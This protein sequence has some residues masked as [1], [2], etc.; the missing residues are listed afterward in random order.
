MIAPGA[1]AWVRAPVA[2]DV[3]VQPGGRCH[4]LAAVAGQLRLDR[5][6]AVLGAPVVGGVNLS[7]GT[8]LD[9]VRRARTA[10]APGR[11]S[12]ARRRT[13]LGT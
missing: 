9:A 4:L 5:G 11:A 12:H 3:I 7:E 1:V 8:R 2:G 10:D 6:I 13:T